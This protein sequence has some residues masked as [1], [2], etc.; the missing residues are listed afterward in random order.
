MCPETAENALSGFKT[1]TNDPGK[2][3]WNTKPLQTHLHAAKSYGLV[4]GSLV[5]LRN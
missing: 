5:N 4:R 2:N 1:V 3:A